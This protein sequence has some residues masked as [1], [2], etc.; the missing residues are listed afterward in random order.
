MRTGIAGDSIAVQ[1]SCRKNKRASRYCDAPLLRWPGS[2][3][4]H[5]ALPQ[6]DQ[7]TCFLLRQ[8][9][10]PP[11]CFENRGICARA[12]PSDRQ[13]RGS[14][15]RFV[16]RKAG[17]RSHRRGSDADRRAAKESAPAAAKRSPRPDRSRR[18]RFRPKDRRCRCVLYST[19]AVALTTANPCAKPARDVHLLEA[20]GREHDA[21]PAAERGR[22]AAHVDGDVEDLAFDR[23][24]Q[25]RLR[26]ASLQMKA[27][28][29]A[30]QPTA[31]GCPARTGRRSRAAGIV[32]RDTSRER[33]RGRRR[34]HR[35][36]PPGRRESR[37]ATTCT[38]GLVLEHP[39]SG[40]DHMR[41]S[42]CA[43][44]SPDT[45]AAVM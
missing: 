45:S 31:S 42:P 44:A 39:R 8:A 24:N 26:V 23:A 11:C 17:R 9:T 12:G 10:C 20:L 5:G 1:K 29:R 13:F 28:K 2:P 6:S 14:C 7:R 16:S 32:R 18:C 37:S 15:Y 35:A 38:S 43:R 34:G 21:H 33:S 25:F 4:I 19:W 30:R 3:S 27:A 41:S 22:A 40:S 36:R